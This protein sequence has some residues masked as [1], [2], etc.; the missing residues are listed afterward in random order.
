HLAAVHDAAKF[1]KTQNTTEAYLKDRIREY[2][3][4]STGHCSICSRP[5]ATAAELYAHIEGC[6]VHLLL[7]RAR[8]D[9]RSAAH[10]EGTAMISQPMEMDGSTWDTRSYMLATGHPG[11]MA[12]WIQGGFPGGYG[13]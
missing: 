13:H 7:Q 2:G 5:F 6:V 8:E 1:R 3:S 4:V 10:G 11:V 12:P 9:N